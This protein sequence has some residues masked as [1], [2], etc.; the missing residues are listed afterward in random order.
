MDKWNKI[1]LH[2][3]GWKI[4]KYLQIYWWFDRFKWWWWIWKKLRMITTEKVDGGEFER[5][6]EW[7]QQRRYLA[8]EIRDNSISISLYVKRDDFHFSIDRML[9]LCS[10]ISYKIFYSKFGAEILRIARTT[11]TCNEFRIFFEA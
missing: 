6:W 9:Y 2:K 1:D 5:S 10:N 3:K 8:I 11:S 4:C 7:Y